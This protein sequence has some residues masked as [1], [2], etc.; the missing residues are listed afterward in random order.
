MTRSDFAALTK[1]SFGTVNN[2]IQQKTE[3]ELLQLYKIAKYTKQ[4]VFSFISVTYQANYTAT[5]EKV[6]RC[7][8]LLDR[9]EEEITVDMIKNIDLSMMVLEE[10]KID[11]VTGAT[12]SS[13]ACNNCV[14]T[15]SGFA[16]RIN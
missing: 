11:A 6:R 15:C 1:L 16:R 10:N 14:N 4:D 8:N 3:P 12:I 5:I 9:I 13:K 2:Y 7:R